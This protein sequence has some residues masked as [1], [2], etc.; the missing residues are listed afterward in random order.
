MSEKLTY[1]SLF[2]GGGVGCFGFK[3]QGYTCVAT[4]EYIERR[5]NIQKHNNKCLYESG[6]ILGDITDPKIF[7]EL[8][9][10]IESFKRKEKIKDIDVV[11]ATPPC[12]GMSVANHKKDNGDIYRNSLVVDAIKIVDKIRPKFFVF[13]NVQSFLNTKC[14]EED[15]E[16][17][18]GEAI[19]QNLSGDY[20]YHSEVINLKN[21]GANSSRTRTIVIG[22]RDDYAEYIS[23]VLL[24]PSYEKEKK[25]KNL[26]FDLP[27]LSKMGETHIDDIYH[28]F[29]SYRKDMRLWIENLSE[30]KSAFDNKDD[31]RKPHRV[32]NGEIIINKN[33]NGDKYK[34]QEW[35]K[36]AACIHTRND[37]F[38]SQNTIHP[39]DDR[40]FSIRELMIMMNIPKTFK[41][42]AIPE[43]ELNKLNQKDRLIFLKENEVNIR[44]SIGEAVPTI[45]MSKIAQNIKNE[46][47]KT[48][49]SN[50]EINK[51]IEKE[52][53]DNLDNLINFIDKKSKDIHLYSIL[54]IS[55]LANMKR[56]DNAAYYT[57]LQT[58]NEIYLNLPEIKKDTVNII[59]PSVGVGN[60]IP[61]IL[62]KYED[63]NKIKL[64][65]F[66]ID[67]D[68][69]K[70]LNKVVEVFDLL[71]ENVEIKIMNKDFL[72]YKFDF[73]YDLL[74]GN[75]PFLKL[76][77]KSNVE[78]YR[79]KYSNEKA[80]N[81]SVFFLEQ[82]L[83]I[84]NEIILIFPKYFLHNDSFSII[85]NKLESTGLL[86]IIDFGEKGFHGVKI[87]TICLC[88]NTNKRNRNIVVKSV[89]HNSE[90]IISKAH[91][92]DN[93]FPNWLIYRNDFFD[94]IVKK[95]NLGVFK[96]FRD[97]QIT[98][99]YL[100][101]NKNHNSIK[102]IRSRNI[103]RNGK[104]LIS[105][106]NYDK[107]INIEDIKKFSVSKYLETNEVYL[108]PNMTY[109]PR[110][111]M[112]PKNTL[113]NG[114]VA[115]LEPVDKSII[116]NDDAINYIG[117]KEF[118]RFYAIARNK[119][120]RSLNIDNNSVF[121]FGIL[122]DEYNAN[123][124]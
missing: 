43:K 109:Y 64:H 13:E 93:K 4:N 12:Q 90:N 10:E 96:V 111:I 34:R 2:S 35:N 66:D 78:H 8:S 48:R 15:E 84:S 58:L 69:L 89:P 122:K 25:L 46:L 32:I 94:S 44:Q 70:V 5:L 119:S 68:S 82:A 76:N 88:I 85:R 53:L 86:S 124:K 63:K 67:E 97:R 27:R 83:K 37:I 51:L 55:E 3:E 50:R 26:I 40:V 81:M 47:R 61:F 77:K 106:E 102:V 1:I 28:N 36:N 118:E 17:T 104:G 16:K 49:L 39:E 41:W 87:E 110:M 20:V 52:K 121:Y 105:I 114:S 107:Y 24:F 38:A 14:Y 11:I 103:D 75:P 117:S 62:K 30:G 101:S 100:H 59:E 91:L 57:E 79:E 74:I 115:I 120:T 6:Y 18:I 99:K 95:L 23:P 54:K 29:K 7:S 31:L 19:N 73:K 113:V 65:I 21:Y 123:N 72:N 98:N 56:Q 42:S 60:F 108:V 116:L 71:N 92:M 33:K 45:I 112:K 80:D 22:V 9:E